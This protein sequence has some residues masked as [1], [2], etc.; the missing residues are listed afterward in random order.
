M[1]NQLFI[2]LPPLDLPAL[3]EPTSSDDESWGKKQ[4]K[5]S[6]Y[7]HITAFMRLTL[8]PCI[9]V[10]FDNI[11]DEDKA[12]SPTSQHETHENEENFRPRGDSETLELDPAE[13]MDV[14][15]HLDALN[16]TM[17]TTAANRERQS[18][19]SSNF[20]DRHSSVCSSFNGSTAVGEMM[21][22]VL[23]NPPP[24]FP[25]VVRPG[26]ANSVENPFSS[27]LSL[28]SSSSFALGTTPQTPVVRFARQAT[29]AASSPSHDPSLPSQGTRHKPVL[30]R[31]GSNLMFMPY[32]LSHLNAPS[33]AKVVM[34]QEVHQEPADPQESSM[35]DY[36]M[37]KPTHRRYR[38][39]IACEECHRQ[40]VGCDMQRPCSRCRASGKAEFCKNQ[41]HCK[42]W[43]QKKPRKRK[44][45]NDNDECD[46]DEKLGME[47]VSKK[48][49]KKLSRSNDG[50][51]ELK[52]MNEDKK[53]MRGFSNVPL[54]ERQ[55]PPL[56]N[57]QD[58]LQGIDDF[59][60][61]NAKPTRISSLSLSL[62]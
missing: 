22:R 47:V 43:K 30:A 16:T 62:K 12:E 34:A 55:L 59:I 19:L 15:Q 46:A 26:V 23:P 50:K 57:L 56:P 41:E 58:S 45:Q 28:S 9:A 1:S 51:E 32:H 33:G 39:R 14:E 18:I 42:T 20:V 6:K 11:R 27:S 35:T 36:L 53:R 38:T 3:E 48:K 8:F 2:A 4:S 52:A 24:P 49:K 13:M 25:P 40:K 44:R 60:A 10:D 21:N 7:K 31:I 17:K 54:W 37:R 5:T 61:P 29:A